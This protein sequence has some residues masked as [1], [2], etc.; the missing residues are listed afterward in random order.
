MNDFRASPRAFGVLRPVAIGAAI[1]LAYVLA[2]ID[3]V[4]SAGG[5]VSQKRIPS[6]PHAGVHFTQ[7]ATLSREGVDL[8]S[9]SE[10]EVPFL[11]PPTRS[12]FMAHWPAIAWAT[13]YRLDVAATPSFQNFLR[14]YRD[15][16]AGSATSRVI[17][18]LNPGATYYYRVRPYNAM[19]AGENSATMAAATA[20][21]GGLIIR[22]TFDSSVTG[23][24]NAAAIEGAV[25]RAIAIYESLFSDQFT[26]YILFRYATTRPNGTPI[27][28]QHIAESAWV[29]Y[30]VD[31]DSYTTDLK[32]DAK[33]GN[34]ATAI[35]TLPDNALSANI[36]A[37]SANGRVIGIPLD[38]AMFADGRVAQ[39]G[40]YDGIVTLKSSVPWQFSRPA[41]AGRYDAQRSIEHEIDEVLGLGS[42][43]NFRS[44]LRPQDLFSWSGNGVRNISATGTRYFSINGGANRIVSFNQNSTGDFGDWLSGG[45]PQSTPYVQNAFSCPGQ[46]SDVT[47]TSSEG[48]NL[49]VIGYDLIS[50]PGFGRTDFNQDGTPDYV[51]FNTST[52]QTAIW[53][54]S[55]N[56]RIGGAYGPTIPPGWSLVDFADFNRDGHADYLLFNP[57]TAQTAIWYLSGGTYL[58][59]V[60]G[61]TL[62]AGWQL[63]ATADVNYDNKPDFV[64]YNASTLQ[65]AWW[66]MNNN[67]RIGGTYSA[68]LPASASLVDIGDFDRNNHP[69]YLLFD[70]TA[71]ASYVTYFG[72]SGAH[73]V[74][75]ASVAS[76]L[77]LVG[78]ADFNRDGNLDFLIFNPSTGETDIQHFDRNFNLITDSS[79]PTLPPGWV[80]VGP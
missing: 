80:L 46:V 22:A 69:D 49:D 45:C 68:T 60:Y 17:T 35:A 9:S 74:P 8:A 67:V 47:A 36:A 75:A 33:S 51:L 64:L 77:Q 5:G 61:P 39:G 65:T 29:Y 41:V 3:A 18:G 59:G 38:P 34:D 71:G 30:L 25:N 43:I 58:G 44:D 70:P 21:G 32:I 76:G 53:Y 23:S 26:A 78:T 54:M 62:P 2:F 15:V 27:A 31:W 16:D 56:L 7:G 12:S 66:Y 19:G 11:A 28:T 57:G 4:P 13:G 14:D 1:L 72:A 40:P 55:D 37:A 24:A 79:G 48:V 20:P 10:M 6:Q 52:R 50:D 63:V 42:H 73:T